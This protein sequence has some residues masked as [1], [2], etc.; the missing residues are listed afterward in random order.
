MEA[1]IENESDALG[2]AETQETAQPKPELTAR[3]L[4]AILVRFLAVLTLVGLVGQLT[5]IIGFVLYWF[6][7][8]SHTPSDVAGLLLT[9]GI[10]L[11]TLVVIGWLWFFPEG[12][13]DRIVPEEHNGYIRFDLSFREI[14]ALVFSLLGV[15]LLTL[16]IPRLFRIVAQFWMQFVRDS[17][18]LRSFPEF[19]IEFY[20]ADFI[21]VLAAIAV[22][23]VLF[24]FSQR[25][26][27]TLYFKEEP[28]Q[29]S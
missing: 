26:V 2:V 10:L 19:V 18:P 15:Y 28:Q 29:Q 23:L 5:N 14:Q 22:A 1:A 25:L 9:G 3:Q 13:T 4:V 21:E 20:F 6:N 16:A 12:I 17:S 11:G 7:Q 27:R 8:T 24:Y